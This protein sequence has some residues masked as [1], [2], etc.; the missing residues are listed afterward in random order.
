MT[1]DA[2]IV[3]ATSGL[4]TVSVAA[5]LVTL[6]YVFDVDVAMSVNVSMLSLTS[7]LR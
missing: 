5:V 1:L 6:R 7:K 2:C 4:S 3:V